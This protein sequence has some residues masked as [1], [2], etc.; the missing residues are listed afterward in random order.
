MKISPIGKMDK[1]VIFAAIAILAYIAFSEDDSGKNTRT[2]KSPASKAMIASKKG[3][4]PTAPRRDPGLW[5]P[6]AKEK[7]E[8]APNFSASNY[9]IVFDGSGS[10]IERQCSGRDP[11][12]NAAKTAV[13][14]FIA[15]LGPE[16]NVALVGFGKTRYQKRNSMLFEHDFTAGDMSGVIDT[17]YSVAPMGKTPLTL[18]MRS[19]F[20]MLEKQAQRQGGYGQYH[21]VII[22]DGVATD[23]DPS[24]MARQIVT[25]SIVRIHVIG[26]CLSGK[27]L[28]NVPGYTRYSTAND[29]Q[30][31]EKGL[32]EV[33]A[34]ADQFDPGV[35]VQ[36]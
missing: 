11:K 17:L 31:L 32:Q 36:Q 9:L 8:M 3:A 34:E 6:P 30:G 5:P 20:M 27:H 18:A 33:L 25:S 14:K 10:M 1:V 35:F 22:T 15:A 19:G 26:F 24:I 7:I 2:Q 13:K 23:G 4:M 16:D 21:M 29:P 28:L 12:I